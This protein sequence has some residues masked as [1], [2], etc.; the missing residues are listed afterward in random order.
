KG[1]LPGEG[2]VAGSRDSEEVFDFSPTRADEDNVWTLDRAG[3]EA[4]GTGS[5]IVKVSAEAVVVVIAVAGA[6][7]LAGARS[8]DDEVEVGGA[9]AVPVADVPLAGFRSDPC[10]AFIGNKLVFE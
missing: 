10:L 7:S 6:G 2:L 9:A 3:L 8:N 4:A 1:F 5:R